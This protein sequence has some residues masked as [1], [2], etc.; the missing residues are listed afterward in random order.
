MPVYFEKNNGDAN[1]PTDRPTG[2]IQS[3]LPFRNLDNRKKGSDLQF[4]FDLIGIMEE[5]SRVS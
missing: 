2:R 5:S 1:Q 3:N 4:Q